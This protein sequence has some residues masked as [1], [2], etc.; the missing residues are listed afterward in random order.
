[1]VMAMVRLISFLR[2]VPSVIGLTPSFPLTISLGHK[3]KILHFRGKAFLHGEVL[4]GVVLEVETA[5]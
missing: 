2:I 1:M 5:W 3:K 4:D